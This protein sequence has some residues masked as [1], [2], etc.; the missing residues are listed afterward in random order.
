M[1]GRL[2][3]VFAL[4]LVTQ[5]CFKG[6]EASPAEPPAKPRHAAV[7]RPFALG[8]NVGQEDWYGNSRIH[9]NLILGNHWQLLSE[10]GEGVP[11]PPGMINADGWLT[12]LPPG[13]IAYR[14][15]NHPNFRNGV[16][17]IIC[18][19]AGKADLE[20]TWHGLIS[21]R[22]TSPGTL[23]FRWTT[24]P[25]QDDRDVTDNILIEVR[26]INR[27][28]PIRD[29]DCRETTLAPSVR[30]NPDYVAMLRGFAVMRYLGPMNANFMPQVT[31]DTRKKPTN[32]SATT[33]EGMALEDLVA[34]ANT[35]H[36]SPWFN[37]PWSADEDYQRRFASYVHDHL[38]PALIAH[39]E[40]SNEVWNGAF[41]VSDVAQ[42][43]GLARKLSTDPYEAL[44]R[45]YAQRV[46]EVM[47]IWTAVY[48]DRPQALVRIAGSQYVNLYAS[49]SILSY[50]DTAK[51]VDALAI[52]PYFAFDKTR[53]P[54]TGVSA[55]M[56]DGM[57][58]SIASVTD[59]IAKQRAI[60][61]QYGLRLITYEAGQHIVLRDNV[62]LLKAINRD[63]RMET[64]YRHYIDQW[65]D[66][67]GDLMVLMQDAGGIGGDGAWGIREYLGQPL[68]DA[69]KARA[70]ASY[71]PVTTAN[72]GPKDA[73][74]R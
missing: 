44:F 42:K 58:A 22:R 20:V 64:A 9:A 8:I 28:D 46:T 48:K 30:F 7:R 61:D 55:A 68:S 12:A 11:V 50:A 59:G 74:V 73:P 54:M 27:A 23:R 39:V 70:V 2:V 52:A 33:A 60:A 1:S 29:I 72:G 43:E 17:D 14:S 66:R 63:P 6:S 35:A 10:K 67:N 24:K 19:Y 65:R 16:A 69:P 34:L 51:W 62:A 26:N 47:K 41:D 25:P 21:D 49:T 13:T 40:V 32:A 15:M 3:C 18:R 56:F 71:L 37:M 36:V 45:R 5:G 57:D 31:W 38:D 4:S 53:V